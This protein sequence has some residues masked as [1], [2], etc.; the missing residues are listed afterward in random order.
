MMIDEKG[1]LWIERH[2][3]PKAQYCP[4]SAE[5]VNCGDWCPL[6]G[7]P[8]REQIEICNGKIL[9]SNEYII[10]GRDHGTEK[11]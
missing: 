11:I 1:F 10:D 5:E 2:G 3:E 6:F 4:H 9:Q 8:W 7:E